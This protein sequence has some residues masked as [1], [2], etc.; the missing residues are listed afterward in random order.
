MHE[1]PEYYEIDFN[2]LS[3]PVRI[4]FVF[5]LALLLIVAGIVFSVRYIAELPARGFDWLMNYV[6]GYR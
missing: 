3:I 1:D 4:L 6:K 2:D 5:V